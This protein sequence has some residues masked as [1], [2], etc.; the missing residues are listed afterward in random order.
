ML[1]LNQNYRIDFLY[2]MCRL[3]NFKQRL[4]NTHTAIFVRLYALILLG[5]STDCIAQ[6]DY[7]D[8][9][10]IQYKHDHQ[11]VWDLRVHYFSGYKGL[12]TAYYQQFR[13]RAKSSF[14]F[15]SGLS[16]QG[17]NSTHPNFYTASPDL[18]KNGTGPWVLLKSA[19]PMRVDTFSTNLNLIASGNIL[20]TVRYKIRDR[21]EVLLL[22][23]LAGLT[24]PLP[25]TG[26]LL[27]SGYDSGKPL[28]TA[29][30]SFI[31]YIGLFGY[32]SGSR[33]NQVIYRYWLH[34][35]WG[36]HAGIAHGIREFRVE[37]PAVN[38]ARR[39]RQN[40]F[41]CSIG[42]AYAPFYKKKN[43]TQIE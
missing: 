24:L 29:F 25:V 7:M 21:D 36:V 8:K 41:A 32:G 6:Y 12:H 14:Y 38:G 28:R 18:T 30:P 3:L 40:I 15:G 26:T 42:I 10:T 34:H 4:V 22:V 11:R 2:N 33:M 43:R 23:E 17:S 39:F 37:A 19:D 20:F 1:L 27:A 13:L 31:N 35:K 5:F 9:F 16:F